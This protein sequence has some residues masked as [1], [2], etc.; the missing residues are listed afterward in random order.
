M[1]NPGVYNLGA[2]TVASAVTDNVITEGVSAGN[3][4]QS[5]IDRL[6]GMTAATIECRFVYGSGGTTCAATVQTS[7]DGTN[8]VD[9]AR[10]D[11]TTASATKVANLSGLLSKGVTA[12]SSLGSEGV[13]DGVLGNR[14]RAKITSTGTYAGTTTISV[15]AS[16]R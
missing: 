3:V 7:F 12:Y 15:K 14:L 8:W 16:V 13:I 2:A 10:F 9:I 4:A 1:D 5:L 6:D 11:F